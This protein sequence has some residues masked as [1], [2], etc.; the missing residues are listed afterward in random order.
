MISL[1]LKLA[2][3]AA[4]LL[5]AFAFAASALHDAHQKGYREGASHVSDSL[6]V[7]RSAESERLRDS[8]G[9]IA[10]SLTAHAFKESAAM[11]EKAAALAKAHPATRQIKVAPAI[12]SVSP[13][14]DSLIQVYV[15][16]EQ[17]AFAL[18]VQAARA[19]AA[20]DSVLTQVALPM[21]EK[22]REVIQLLDSALTV[23]RQARAA[24][25]TLTAVYA[26][27]V[28]ELTVRAS[29]AVPQHSRWAIAAKAVGAGALVYGVL[30]SPNAVR[31][32]VRQLAR[33]R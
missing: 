17:R 30:K 32:V 19:W 18:P 1:Q 3:A 4:A 24:A 23:E 27:R 11:Q 26:K 2:I 22:Q 29:S 21:L 33:R 12:D 10:D 9:R 5:A 15:E 6:Y 16:S 7:I 8:I 25:D 28:R 31:W 14:G 20:E 13:V